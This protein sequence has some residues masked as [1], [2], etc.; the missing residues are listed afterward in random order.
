MENNE[1]GN[2]QESP[3]D[4]KYGDLYILCSKGH[5]TRIGENVDTGLQLLLFNKENSFISLNCPEC[6]KEY[7]LT[8]RLLPAENPPVEEAEVI[9]ETKEEIKDELQEDTTEE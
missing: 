9:E 8:L 3:I 6:D 1:K 2:V 5:K 4:Y 7:N